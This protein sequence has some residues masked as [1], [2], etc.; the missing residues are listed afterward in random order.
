MAYYSKLKA[1]FCH[2]VAGK[3]KEGKWATAITIIIFSSNRE[4]QE[5]KTSSRLG[6]KIRA[7]EKKIKRKGKK[8]ASVYIWD[9][10]DPILI[11]CMF[12]CAAAQPRISLSLHC[13]YNKFRLPYV[14]WPSIYFNTHFRFAD[15]TSHHR[16]AR[17]RIVTNHNPIIRFC[18]LSARSSSIAA[19]DMRRLTKRSTILYILYS[20]C[21]YI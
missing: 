12:L 7:T 11:Y 14:I 19:I 18:R 1:Y 16:S 3:Q 6:A 21:I 20:T 4:S 15:A 13:Q 8:N 10:N 9:E 17:F 5:E 2:I